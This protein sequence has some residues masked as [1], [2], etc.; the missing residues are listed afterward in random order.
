MFML[1][2]ISSNLPSVTVTT[3]TDNLKNLLRFSFFFSSFLLVL[4]F[5][6]TPTPEGVALLRRGSLSSVLGRSLQAWAA[7][8][9]A[10]RCTVK[11]VSRKL[12][13][14]SVLTSICSRGNVGF[15]VMT[16]RKVS[17][18]MDVDKPTQPGLIP[19]INIILWYTQTW[20]WQT[21]RDWLKIR[22]V[23]ATEAT[24]KHRNQ[25]QHKA[26]C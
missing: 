12:L 19:G 21:E 24:A 10:R 2:F 20:L 11:T 4:L 22:G 15:H 6:L 1:I 16:E 7:S 13:F 23:A 9:R 3:W 18:L 5:L 26:G 25:T 14:G 8:F 17:F